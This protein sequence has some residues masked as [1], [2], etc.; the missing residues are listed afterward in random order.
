M[1]IIQAQC[2]SVIQLGLS[3]ENL[4]RQVEFDVSAWIQLYGEGDVSLLARRPGETV[5]YPVAV[6]RAENLVLW[7]LG[8]VDTAKP[9]Y[10]QAELLYYVGDAL[11]KSQVWMTR[12]APALSPENATEPVPRDPWEEYLQQVTKAGA[13]ALAAAER[14]EEA[15]T[16]QPKIQDGTWWVWSAV[17]NAYQDTGEMARGPRGAVGPQGEPG[18]QGEQGPE[19]KPGPQG[20]RGIQ[21]DTGP[22]GPQGPEGARG[23]QGEPGPKGEA[24]PK[25]ETGPVGP[26]G[27][28]GDPGPVTEEQLNAAIQAAIYDSWG[29]SY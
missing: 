27:P 7:P 9:G 18:P 4:A 25:G 26:M 6:T 22:I 1:Q 23:P 16:H 3:G 13:G 2:G 29:A 14:A 24:G 20:E 12:I 21:G 15:L 8:G 11:V 17:D 5:P 28:Q 10:G 19:G